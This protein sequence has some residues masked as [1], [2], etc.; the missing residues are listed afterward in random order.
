MREF[1]LALKSLKAL[2]AENWG[3]GSG[4]RTSQSC[5]MS[6]GALSQ[7]HTKHLYDDLSRDEASILAQ[8]HLGHS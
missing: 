1:G 6:S 3:S 2:E 8:L 7:A 4:K 5:F